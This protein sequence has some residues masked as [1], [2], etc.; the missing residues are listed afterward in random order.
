MNTDVKAIVHLGSSHPSTGYT[1]H[2]VDGSPIGA[3]HTLQIVQYEGDEGFYLL[4]LDANDVEI[5]DTYHSTL[6]A[7]KEQARLE[8]GVERNAWRTC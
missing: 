2:V 4:Y 7:A 3:V 5:T 8:F 1:V 6:E